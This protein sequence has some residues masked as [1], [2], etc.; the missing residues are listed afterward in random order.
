[1]PEEILSNILS[2]FIGAFLGA[3]LGAWITSRATKKVRKTEILQ[4]R[5]DSFIENVSTIVSLCRQRRALLLNYQFSSLQ[6]KS[7][8]SILPIT[9]KQIGDLS[10]EI[11]VLHFKIIMTLHTIHNEK[12]NDLKSNFLKQ[13]K[14]I[15]EASANNTHMNKFDYGSVLASAKQIVEK[16]WQS[17]EKELKVSSLF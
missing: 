8:D 3:I 15:V 4:I 2:G 1:M 10:T 12:I 17:I 9:S 16:E 5:L 6:P 14:Q 7:T 11:E 13:L